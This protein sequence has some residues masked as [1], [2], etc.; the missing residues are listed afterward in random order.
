MAPPKCI[1]IF[2]RSR[3][4]L[5][6]YNKFIT[7]WRF[8]RKS[9]LK[10]KQTVLIEKFICSLTEKKLI[11]FPSLTYFI[12]IWICG[13]KTENFPIWNFV[14]LDA[15]FWVKGCHKA[16]GLSVS[17][18]KISKMWFVYVNIWKKGKLFDVNSCQGLKIKYLWST[19][20]FASYV[21][22]IRTWR[23]SSTI[24]K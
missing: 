18:M 1:C 10:W 9:S 15:R 22:V 11:I 3:F 8:T 16:F 21:R 7:L 4:S 24:I 20:T 17:Q 2:L 14:L 13:W 23:T 19:N 12:F 5:I 6:K